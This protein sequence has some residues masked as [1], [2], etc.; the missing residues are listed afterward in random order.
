MLDSKTAGAMAYLLSKTLNMLLDQPANTGRI[1]I[2]FQAKEAKFLFAFTDEVYVRQ[3]VFF[4]NREAVVLRTEF[5]QELSL[6]FEKEHIA[7]ALALIDCTLYFTFDHLYVD[8]EDAF[9]EVKTHRIDKR[10]F[11]KAWV[12]ARD[13]LYEGE[14]LTNEYISEV[15]TRARD[16]GLI[17]AF[18]FKGI[19]GRVFQFFV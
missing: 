5:E 18:T 14:S 1:A 9:G 16:M 7:L 12:E 17:D 4:T 3:F 11:A 19:D 6:D 8:Y 10:D 15:L 13:S 2:Y